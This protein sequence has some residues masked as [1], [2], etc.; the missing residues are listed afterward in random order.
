M[1][2]KYGSVDIFRR[3]R[4]GISVWGSISDPQPRN[5]YGGSFVFVE[6]NEH[7]IDLKKKKTHS[8]GILFE[9]KQEQDQNNTFVRFTNEICLAPLSLSRVC[10]CVTENIVWEK[11]HTG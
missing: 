1:Q 6:I 5:D 2:S 10:V 3:S 4:G 9:S 11:S 7:E 8:F